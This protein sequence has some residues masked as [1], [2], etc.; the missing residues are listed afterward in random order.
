MSV[1]EK[2]TAIADAIRRYAREPLGKLTLDEMAENVEMVYSIGVEDGEPLGFEEGKNEGIEQ[3]KKDAYDYFWDTFQ[4][5]GERVLYQNA[6]GCQWTVEL[7]KPKYQMIPTSAFYMFY[8]NLSEYLVIEDF[9]DFCDELAIEQGKTFETHPDM[10]DE[11]GHYQL[12]DFKNCTNFQYGL[13][14]L[15]T[16]HLGVIDLGKA[17]IT[18]GL[19]YSH[20]AAGNGIQKIDKIISS[21]TTNFVDSTF[22]NATYL[23][24]VIFEG[25]IAK[26]INFGTCPLNANSVR[27]V[28]SVLSPDVTGQT[29]TF[30]A[31]SR[32]YFS[33]ADWTELITPISN[34]YDGN[35]TV[36]I[37]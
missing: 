3:G 2:L 10:F 25:V 7:F 20:N 23:S 26:S 22:Q 16:K 31:T 6:F 5:N 14:A 18:Y 13:A 34:Q 8:S 33:D 37:P 32:A 1:A 12:I 9:V 19:F 30:S 15:H 29:V 24:E 17:K 36:A 21:A 4:Q 35:W 27:S 28:I 11:N